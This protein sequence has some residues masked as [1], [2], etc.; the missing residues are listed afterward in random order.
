MQRG[1]LALVL[2]PLRRE[3]LRK[4]EDALPVLAA[5]PAETRLSPLLRRL[6]RFRSWFWQW[7]RLARLRRAGLRAPFCAF[8]S[9]RNTC[10][11]PCLN[12]SGGPGRGCRCGGCVLRRRGR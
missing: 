6:L 3:R 2:C 8:L 7:F 10:R 1:K 4:R 12:P 11:R 9:I 5:E